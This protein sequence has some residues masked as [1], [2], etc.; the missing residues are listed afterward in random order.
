M[1]YFIMHEQHKVLEEKFLYGQQNKKAKNKLHK[2][3]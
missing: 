1:P 2:L 3:Y